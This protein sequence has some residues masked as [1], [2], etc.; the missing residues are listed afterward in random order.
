MQLGGTRIIKNTKQYESV[1]ATRGSLVHPRQR[2]LTTTPNSTT[3]NK[4]ATSQKKHGALKRFALGQLGFPFRYGTSPTKQ[5]DRSGQPL[6]FPQNKKSLDAQTSSPYLHPRFACFPCGAKA[7]RAGELGVMLQD[8]GHDPHGLRVRD[9]GLSR[10][11][12]TWA[13]KRSSPGNGR[14]NN[15]RSILGENSGPLFGMVYI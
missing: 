11:G 3:R 5:E 4:K 1:E 9:V 14:W 6:P 7:F 13:K 12:S 8:L 15:W 10:N 2:L